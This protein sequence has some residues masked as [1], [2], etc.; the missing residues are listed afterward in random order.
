VSTKIACIV[1]VVRMP[2]TLSRV[3]CARGVTMLSFSPTSALRSVD[4]PTFGRPTRA[5]CP[6]RV[7]G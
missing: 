2:V 6:D 5:T 1:G 7:G 4:F 3:V